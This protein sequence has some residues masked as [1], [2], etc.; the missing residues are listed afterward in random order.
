MLQVLATSIARA[1]RQRRDRRSSWRATAVVAAMIVGASVLG[2][3]DRRLRSRDLADGLHHHP[4]RGADVSRIDR[5]RLRRT[6]R[7]PGKV[8]GALVVMTRLRPGLDQHRRRLD[9]LSAHRLR[10]RHHLLEHVRRLGHRPSAGAR[11]PCCSPDRIRAPARP[12]TPTR[13]GP[14]RPSFRPGCSSRSCWR[15]SR[16]SRAPCWAS[17]GTPLINLGVD[18]PAAAG[19]DGA[20]LTLGTIYVVFFAANLVEPFQEAPD[21]ARRAAGVVSGAS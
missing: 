15:C 4:L 9:P 3:H 2:Y 21:P 20:I 1:G 14:W 13:S 12:S 5:R 8:I 7:P 18:P 10:R 17:S 6:R 11:R 16:W 19:L